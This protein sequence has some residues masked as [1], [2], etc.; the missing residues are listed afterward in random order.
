MPRVVITGDERRHNQIAAVEEGGDWRMIVPFAGLSIKEARLIGENRHLCLSSYPDNRARDA[1][2]SLIDWRSGVER[3]RRTMWIAGTIHVTNDARFILVVAEIYLHVMRADDLSTVAEGNTV[4]WETKPTPAGRWRGRLFQSDT[5]ASRGT[6]DPVILHTGKM[7]HEDPAGRLFFLCCSAGPQR[8]IR[9]AICDIDLADGTVS[10]AEIPDTSGQWL[11]FS[12]SR[13]FALARHVR[14]LAYDDGQ[15]TKPGFGFGRNPARHRDALPDGRLRF[16][17]ALELWETDPP[18]LKAIL[19]VQMDAIQA[20]IDAATGKPAPGAWVRFARQ[21]AENPADNVAPNWKPTPREIKEHPERQLWATLHD[22]MNIVSAVTW[23]QDEIGFWIQFGRWS[24][25]MVL[26]RRTGIDGS[27]SP[28]FA[29]A[30]FRDTGKTAHQDFAGFADADRVAIQTASGR[31]Y[32]RRSWCDSE[33]P[34]RLV[35]EDEDGFDP[36]ILPPTMEKPPEDAVARAL[37]PARRHL[38]TLAD[39][40]RDAVAACLDALAGDVGT[41]LGALVWRE[42]FRIVFEM[43]FVVAGDTVPEAEFFRHVHETRLPVVQELRALLTAYLAA[44]ARLLGGP[45]GHEQIWGPDGMG[46]FGPAMQALL[47]LDPG[48]H[49]V[50]REYLARRDGEHEVYSTDVIMR[51]VVAAHGW[52]DPVLQRLGFHCALIRAR[53][54]R[55]ASP[56]LLNEYGLLDAA[57]G[58]VSAAA[59]AAMIAEEIDGFVLSSG[60]GSLT[61]G[62]LLAALAP[63]LRGGG[64]GQAVLRAIG[65]PS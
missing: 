1:T 54:G 5:P 9:Y 27:L 52:N 51:S 42:G 48:A 41:R 29:F 63:S 35:T 36:S 14:T 16:G 3:A 23:E 7:P 11:W 10:A 39:F 60:D 25:T 24:E 61:Q 15:A 20:V 46:A 18:A 33:A 28:L 26:F 45:P 53:D 58:T 37:G 19:V 22:R 31:V 57:E 13:R 6:E 8:R 55:R 47:L 2:L 44:Q 56:G 43:A 34:L 17:R 59:F 38:V 65:A 62:R 40:S 49:D 32:L 12:P 64:Y 4:R 50:F 21:S 30:R